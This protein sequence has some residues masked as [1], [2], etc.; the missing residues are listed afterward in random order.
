MTTVAEAAL[1]RA[2]EY[3]QNRIDDL[4]NELITLTARR[5]GIQE[6]LSDLR[7]ICADEEKNRTGSES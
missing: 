5:D 6:S 3:L 7:A 2:I 4:D 1:T